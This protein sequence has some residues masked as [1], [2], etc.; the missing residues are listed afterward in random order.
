MSRQG[1]F[2]ASDSGPD[3]ARS[4]I[5]RASGSW[6][7]PPMEDFCPRSGRT[8][9]SD[10]VLECDTYGILTDVRLALGQSFSSSFSPSQ[11]LVRAFRRPHIICCYSVTLGGSDMHLGLMEKDGS[12]AIESPT[13]FYPN[14]FNLKFIS[15]TLTDQYWAS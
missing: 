8:V 1:R 13:S 2:K 9:Q 14:Y 7:F 10:L 6:L 5:T 15:A 3:L 11:L 12:G 4:R